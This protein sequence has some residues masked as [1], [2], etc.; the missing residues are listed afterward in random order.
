LA[1]TA[2][3]AHISTDIKSLFRLARKTGIE[4]EDFERIVRTELEFLGML[5]QEG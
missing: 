5:E 4:R 3:K 1:Q 2:I